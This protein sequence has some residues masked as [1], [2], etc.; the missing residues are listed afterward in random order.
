MKRRVTHN[1]GEEKIEAK[2]EEMISLPL[3]E[4]HRIGLA[5]GFMARLLE[6]NQERLYG[7]GLFKT[8]QILKRK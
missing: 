4:R 7:R 5:K 8:I 3:E 6:K 1:R 2:I